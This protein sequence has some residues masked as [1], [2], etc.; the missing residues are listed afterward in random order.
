AVAQLRGAATWRV[1]AGDTMVIDAGAMGASV[2]ASGASLRLEVAMRITPSD[3]RVVAASTITA[4]AVAL[5]TVAVYQG[6]IK[7]T[8]GGQT[9]NVGAGGAVEIKPGEP[10]RELRQVAAA[11]DRPR[12]P[13]DP[14]RAPG[15]PG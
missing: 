6:H 1:D 2:E 3:G 15:A 11:A 9:V 7:V 4:A 13:G 12:A 5:V 8:S 14:A 10:A